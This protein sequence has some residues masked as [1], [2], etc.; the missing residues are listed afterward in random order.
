MILYIYV[1]L[2]VLKK[3]GVSSIK[4]KKDLKSMVCVNFNLILNVL[5]IIRLHSNDIFTEGLIEQVLFLGL[6]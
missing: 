1:N 4:T 5:L 2:F 6:L 3:Q